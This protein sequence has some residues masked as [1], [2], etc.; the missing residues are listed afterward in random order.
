M[1]LLELLLG[2]LILIAIQSQYR[3][4]IRS[5]SYATPLF[6]YFLGFVLR[7]LAHTDRLLL[8]QPVTLHMLNGLSSK[9][10]LLNSQLIRRRGVAW[11]AL[12]LVHRSL[13]AWESSCLTLIL[14]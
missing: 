12:L 1:L 4:D 7:I 14:S 2:Q 9:R 5:F 3:F 6:H 10:L 8:I 11:H 13:P